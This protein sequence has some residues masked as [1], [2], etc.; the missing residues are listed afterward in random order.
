MKTA[1]LLAASA[2]AA[3]MSMATGAATFAADEI[4]MEQCFGIAL[5]GAND[6]AVDSVG[7]TCSGTS[8]ADR[9]PDAYML[10]PKGTCLKIAG[11]TLEPKK[12]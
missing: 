12:A 6:C 1:Q 5:A 9:Q 2:L 10:V 11:G 4:E 8:T 7:S 3:A